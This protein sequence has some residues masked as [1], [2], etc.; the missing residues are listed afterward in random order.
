[1]RPAGDPPTEQ[2][3]DSPP[4]PPAASTAQGV[5][6]EAATMRP[7]AS[8]S[9]YVEGVHLQRTDE[10]VREI[11][12]LAGVL[13]EAAAARVRET[14]VGM[15]DR[16]FAELRVTTPD[17]EPR[18]FD[19][20]LHRSGGL[21]LLGDWIVEWLSPVVGEEVE[22]DPPLPA[23]AITGLAV[24]VVAVGVA[25]AFAMV[26][27]L[28][29]AFSTEGLEIH[30]AVTAR[31]L[32][33]AYTLGVLLTFA[34]V[35]VW[36]PEELGADLSRAQVAQ[37]S[38]YELLPVRLGGAVQTIGATAADEEA[39]ALLHIPVGSPV[40]RCERIT[41]VADGGPVLVAEYV[42]PGHLTEFIVDLPHV[43]AS[44]AP[45]GLQLVEP[46]PAPA[47]RSL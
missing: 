39:A 17:G 6:D 10:N 26:T 9:P 37:R 30:H 22:H 29:D 14:A 40:L 33:V 46:R 3:A 16:A 21:L 19:A 44:I 36:C 24:L 8:E 20:T 2:A 18:V 34:I 7:T 4:A 28:S 5:P 15:Q 1:M 25:V 31:S 42:F 43:E 32:A 23:L 13:G 47:R 11:E 12:A 27:M 45:S 35:T 38:F 41:S